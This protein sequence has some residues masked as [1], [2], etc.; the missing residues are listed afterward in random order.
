MTPHLTTTETPFFLV[1]GRDPNLSLHQLLKLMQQ[2]L[3]DPDS[4]CLDLKSHCL[5]IAIAKKTLD[6][7]QFK[8]AQQMTNHT[9]PNFKIGDRL[10]FK[11]RQP[12]KWDLERRSGYRIVHLECNRQYLHIENQAT[13]KT[14]PY[15]VKDVVHKLPVELLNVEAMFGRA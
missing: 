7:N 10:F 11:K 12:G 4:G 3:S 5:A 9:P 8:H 14:R 6:E 15:D 2:F 13:G 1:Y